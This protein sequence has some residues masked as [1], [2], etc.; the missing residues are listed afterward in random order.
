FYHA[1]AARPPESPPGGTYRARAA[2]VSHCYNGYPRSRPAA[3]GR[4]HHRR[5]CFT[6]HHLQSAGYGRCARRPARL[7]RSLT[8]E[9]SPAALARKFEHAAVFY[10]N[11]DEYLDAVLG[12]VGGGLERADPVFVAVPGPTVGLLREHLDS[13]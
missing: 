9:R 11:T 7:W 6:R 1:A 8:R 13:Q 12:F 4:P 2:T 10:R 5:R 3:T